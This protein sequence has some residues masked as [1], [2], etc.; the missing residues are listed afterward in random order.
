M[1]P[2]LIIHYLFMLIAAYAQGQT[3]VL[4]KATPKHDSI[5]VSAAS[6][7]FKPQFVTRTSIKHDDG[8]L[9]DQVAAHRNSR[10]VSS[11]TV[12]HNAKVAFCIDT[13]FYTEEQVNSLPPEKIA[14][15]KSAG[16]MELNPAWFTDTNFHGYVA[17]F[18]FEI[19]G[20][21]PGTFNKNYT[22]SKH[23]P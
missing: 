23:L 14:R 4:G 22:W 13:V 2:I 9:S 8:S 20:I 17:V 21:P 15:I 19:N 11:T 7:I 10:V 16:V 6:K 12:P 18:R 5:P 1:K 3:T